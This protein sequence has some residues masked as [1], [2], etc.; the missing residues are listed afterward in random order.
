MI[1]QLNCKMVISWVI[2]Y[3]KFYNLL[4]LIYTLL[5]FWGTIAFMV[6]LKK[7]EEIQYVKN[8]KKVTMFINIKLLSTVASLALIITTIASNQR[9]WY[10]MYEDKLP[11]DH[12]RLRKF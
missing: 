3:Y 9:C 8:I 6:Q 2:D 5:H 11:D 1:K 7:R 10:V 4:Q 12:T